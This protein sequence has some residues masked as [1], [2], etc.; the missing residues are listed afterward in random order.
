VD[1]ISFISYIICAVSPPEFNFTNFTGG[2]I[3]RWGMVPYYQIFG[4]FTWGIILGFIGA[5]LYA[6]ER[7]L[8]IAFIYLVLVGIF[9]SIILPMAL[10]YLFGLL[11]AFIVTIILY[12][13]FVEKR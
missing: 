1:F 9:F 7:S 4:N 10:V 8:G 2:G 11:F 6:S 3:I 5:G 13:T 12:R